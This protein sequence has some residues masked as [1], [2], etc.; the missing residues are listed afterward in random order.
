MRLKT[1]FIKKDIV[2][3]PVCLIF[4]VIN[5]GA[6][7]SGGRRRAKRAVCLTNL[8]QLTLAWTQYAGDNDGKIVCGDT[9]EYIVDPTNP[10]WVRRDWLPYGSISLSEKEQAIRDGALWPYCMD[11]KLYKCPLGIRIETRSYSAVDAMNCRG[12]DEYRVR[13]KKITDILNP[14]ERAVFLD[15]GGNA[16]VTLGGW[17]QYSI[18]SSGFDRWIWWDPPPIRHDEG[19]TFSFA[20]GHSEYWKWKDP[21]TVEWGK[22]MMAFSPPQINNPDITRSQIAS[23]GD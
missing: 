21:R 7:S 14:S 17:T 20:D 9:E 22:T 5:V 15:D 4:M 6:I 12:W 11:L 19:T 1:A 3:V 18:Y 10:C 13:L 8:K 23:W 16:G 2:V